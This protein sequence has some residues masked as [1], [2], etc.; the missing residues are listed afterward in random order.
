MNN[1]SSNSIDSYFLNNFKFGNS[2][3][4]F[5]KGTRNTLLNK[6]NRNCLNTL[7]GNED[8]SYTNI[9]YEPDIINF[10]KK[11]QSDKLYLL[12]LLKR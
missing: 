7:Y 11:K 4:S 8:T 10:G 2:L 9:S 12:S 5:Y 1:D 6:N 3:E